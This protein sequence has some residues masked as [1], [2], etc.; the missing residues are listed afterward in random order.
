MDIKVS[1]NTKDLEEMVDWASKAVNSS[2]LEQKSL[3][4]DITEHGLN[5]RSFNGHSFYESWLPATVSNLDKQVE[6]YAVFGTQLKAVV[7]SIKKYKSAVLSFG[8]GGIDIKAGGAKLFI[9]KMR[10]KPSILEITPT[11]LGV[12][13][14]SDFK[15]VIDHAL[16]TTNPG[17]YSV[18][19]LSSVYLEFNSDSGE[20][21]VNSTDRYQLTVRRIAFAPEL[22]DG[23]FIDKKF[24]INSKE[25]QGLISKMPYVDSVDVV[26]GSNQFGLSG[27]SYSGYVNVV[28]ASPANFKP[29]ISR[30]FRNEIVLNKQ[31][32]L[33][34]VK[35]I[36]SSSQFLENGDDIT[37]L[38][39]DDSGKFKVG[40]ASFKNVVE[41]NISRSNISEEFTFKVNSRFFITALNSLSTPDFAILF[42][43]SNAEIMF[44]EILSD[45]TL[46]GDYYHMV[47]TIVR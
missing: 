19:A 29:L 39:V 18:P 25:I 8:D 28:D 22:V 41:G 1:V 26:Y 2:G 40:D 4:I 34:A 11:K 31:E 46:N 15:K 3:S 32:V 44:K 10:V 24:L 37:M 30:E 38:S 17:D 20:L 35:I 45:E 21:L 13:N 7:S 6:G 16:T 43:V 12:I 36:N 47:M 14:L 42:N 23:E 27:G 9:P 5:F 33:D